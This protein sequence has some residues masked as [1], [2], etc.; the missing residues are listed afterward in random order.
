MKSFFLL[1]QGLVNHVLTLRG[2][3]HSPFPA[4]F[5][6]QNI[7]LREADTISQFFSAI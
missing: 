2:I 5:R 1:I 6:Q 3:R 7:R 4:V